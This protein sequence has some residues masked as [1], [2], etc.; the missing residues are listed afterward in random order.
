M[1]THLLFRPENEPTCNKVFNEDTLIQ[2]LNLHFLFTEMAQD[3]STLYDIVKSVVLNS[4]SNPDII[5]Y[6]QEIVKDGI[7]NPEAIRDLFAIAADAMRE[8]A[9]YKEFTQP[10]YARVVP[11]SVRVL[12]AVGL[13][14]ILVDKLEKLKNL[15]EAF[16]K[17]FDSTGLISFCNRINE[18]LP[19]AFFQKAKMHI[20][21]LKYLCEGGKLI[22]G[23]R[24]GKGLKG[25]GYVLRKLPRDMKDNLLKK[26]N[27]KDIQWNE[28]I[29]DN[30]SIAKSAREMEDAGLIRILRIIN[31][32]NSIIQH[33][34]G[35][36]RFEAGFY[37]GSVNLYTTLSSIHA[38]ISFPRPLESGNK[39]LCFKGLYDISLALNEKK[40]PV[41][42][43]IDASDKTLFIITGANQGGKSTFLRSVA[44][45]QL[46]MQCGL[47]VP[48]LE[49]RSEVCCQLFTHFTREEDAGMNSGKLDEELLRMDEI[50][51]NITPNSI[52]FMNESFSTTTE[53][54]GSKI[55]NDII[56]ALVESGVRV[57]F[58]T[59]L[60][61]YADAIYSQDPENVLFL[62]AGRNKDGNRSFV[63]SPGEPLKTSFALDLFNHILNCSGGV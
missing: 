5:L 20:R 59:H 2:D 43:D 3:N 35:S 21:D 13:L 28:I 17:S 33:F 8:A 26:R 48:A 25:T 55:A 6:R 62:R 50:I 32:F 14:E 44:L 47:F 4:L 27:Q 57:F 52:L 53:R 42:N 36:L 41:Q 19:N 11:V 54:D 18:Y 23:V 12:K 40:K 38:P 7:K 16:R 29:L 39:S 24:I 15:T 45:A 51:A 49:F 60:F 37:L 30:I 56:S 61:E 63:V 46:L 1:K 9:Y 34:F 10:N 58:V 31:R 22:L